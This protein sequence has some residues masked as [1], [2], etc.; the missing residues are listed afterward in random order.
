MA[1]EAAKSSEV[2]RLSIKSKLECY[3]NMRNPSEQALKAMTKYSS[4]PNSSE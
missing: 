3:N 1:Y 4:N 2:R